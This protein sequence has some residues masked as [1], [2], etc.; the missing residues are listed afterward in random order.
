MDKP[1]QCQRDSRDL[2]SRHRESRTIAGLRSSAACSSRTA[3]WPCR[4][5]TF[6]F[7]GIAAGICHLKLAEI[8]D[9]RETHQNSLKITFSAVDE[10]VVRRQ[11]GSEVGK[12]LF[13]H[14]S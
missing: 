6:W 2:Q 9:S 8:R 7:A 4:V 11:P 3:T 10:V 1:L 13:S 5:E 12:A 14:R